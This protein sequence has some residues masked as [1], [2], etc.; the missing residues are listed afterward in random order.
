M[1]SNTLLRIVFFTW[2]VSFWWKE[3]IFDRKINRGKCR[4]NKKYSFRNKTKKNKQINSK[5]ITKKIN[6]FKIVHK[7]LNSM[8]IK[9]KRWII[10]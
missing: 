2:Y 6:K 3:S 5:L 10:N 9:N 1:Y 8:I 4:K 7:R